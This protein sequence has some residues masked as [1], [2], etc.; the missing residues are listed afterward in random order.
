MIFYLVPAGEGPEFHP[1]MLQPTQGDANK[2]ARERGLK[3]RAR[4][5]EHQ[6][7]T[8]KAGLMAYI[9]DLLSR[10]GGPVGYAG[11]IPAP[12]HQNTDA[13]DIDIAEVAARDGAAAG[14]KFLTPTP[15]FA[16]P[17]RPAPRLHPS[18]PTVDLMVDMID[19]GDVDARGLSN[20][21][22]AVAHR[23]ERMAKEMA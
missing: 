13:L 8:D 6:V 5:M 12:A 22:E 20:L 16:P 2:L 10:S 18:I 14:D 3:V 4:D 23:F 11:S 7:P 19:N 21:A 1:P 17:V 9:N 15:T